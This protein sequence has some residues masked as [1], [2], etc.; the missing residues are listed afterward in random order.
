MHDYRDRA[1]AAVQNVTLD[2]ATD[3]TFTGV[4]GTAEVYQK[5]TIP[6]A[7]GTDLRCVR[8]AWAG[9]T[10]PETTVEQVVSISLLDG[11]GRLVADSRPQ[12]GSFSPNYA[13]LLVRKPTAATGRL[14]CR[15]R[16]P[17]RSP[18][19]SG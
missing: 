1:Q 12:G 6:V 16:P 9:E 3:P 14:S 4:A 10:T 8:A 5:A 17:S 11:S 18:G 2:P 13:N 19:P 7:G 15:R